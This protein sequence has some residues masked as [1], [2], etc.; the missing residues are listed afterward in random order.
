MK[1]ES[2]KI[3]LSVVVI[4]RNEGRRL[5]ACLKAAEGIAFP[6]E[7]RELIYVDSMSA[8]DS[9]EQA[10]SMGIPVISLNNGRLTAA[11]ARNTG[12]QATKGEF[13]LFLDADTIIDPL[14]VSE[15]M[16]Q[17]NNP[18]VGVVTGKLSERFPSDSIYNRV[19]DLDWALSKQEYCGGNAL[20]R[21]GA[22]EKV[23]GYNTNLIAGEEPEMCRRMLAEGYQ[24]R[25][26]NIPMARHD[27]GMKTLRQYWKR[28]F[29]NGYTYA[30]VS[31]LP[32]GSLWHRES[33]H[34]YLK[35][36]ILIL[37]FVLAVLLALFQGFLSPL[38][39]YFLFL[40]L[41]VLRTALRVGKSHPLKTALLYGLHCHL[42]HVPMFFGQLACLKDRWSSA[43]RRIIE[44]K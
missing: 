11:L 8:D 18:D 30:F 20:V 22:L 4:G 27:M 13:I 15:A 33:R 36:S 44:Y 35:G 5:E 10:K 43:T 41:L 34:N 38:A 25:H 6:K 1:N 29:R 12:W 40:G 28:C 24:M 2:K 31:S 42:Q 9:V 37:G 39:F 17:F 21:R 26:I 32:E 7:R 19:H 23:Q 16:K 3:T 14:F